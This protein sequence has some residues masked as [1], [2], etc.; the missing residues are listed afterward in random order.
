M[1]APIDFTKA[2]ASGNDFIIIRDRALSTVR[3]R[4]LAQVLCDRVGGVGADGLLVLSPGSS[5]YDF[6]MRIFNL[7]G[8][9]ASMCGNGMR[10]AGLFWARLKKRRQISLQAQTKAGRIVVEVAQ[11]VVKLQIPDPRPATLDIRLDLKGKA[12]N[13]HHIDTGVPHTVMFSEEIEALDVTEF[14]RD[15]R[16][17]ERFKPQGTN[18]DFVQILDAKTIHVRTYERGVEG[19]TLACGTGSIAA[20]L[21][22][23]HVLQMSGNCRLN[24]RTKSGEVLI[25][26]FVRE[27]NKISDVW[28]Q[29]SARIVFEGRISDV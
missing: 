13:V 22:A 5:Q 10:C 6:K 27:G 2:V 23:G 3:L 9:E 25:V 26:Y 16:F 14:G 7:D 21:I 17:H 15:I 29:G 24:V 12:H 8:S 1:S 18:V 28:L 11:D 20:A 19:E 4:K